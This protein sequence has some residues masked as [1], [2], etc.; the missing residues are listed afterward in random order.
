MINNCILILDDLGVLV[1]RASAEVSAQEI[2]FK[3]GLL[4]ALGDISEKLAKDKY[5][6]D[7]ELSPLSTPAQDEFDEEKHPRKANGQFAL[8]GLIKI[9]T[10]PIYALNN[11]DFQKEVF[12][13]WQEAKE[14]INNNVVQK[15]IYRSVSNEEAEKIKEKT[16]LDLTGYKHE[17]TNTDVKHIFKNHGNKKKEDFR[18]QI[19][20][21][22]K[23]ISLIPEITANYDDVILDERLSEGKK[24]LLYKKKIN[25][26]LIYLET[27]SDKKKELRSKTMYIKKGEKAQHAN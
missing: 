9:K 22:A 6:L 5:L 20:V 21:T 11:E 13:L 1:E 19:A 14:N 7:M 25:D 8:K 23:E 17:I 2:I 3:Q 26:M 18:G 16:G 15:I 24:V 10:E 27:I 4:N 12:R